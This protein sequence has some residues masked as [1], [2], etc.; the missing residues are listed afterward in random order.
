MLT[1]IRARTNTTGI[2]N[3][4]HRR[5]PGGRSRA[6]RDAWERVTALL[7]RTLGL[8]RCWC[9]RCVLYRLHAWRRYRVVHGGGTWMRTTVFG[10]RVRADRW[11]YDTPE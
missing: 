10:I 1:T 8:R 5:H 2:A 11:L 3:G 6:A 7:R 4:A 9:A